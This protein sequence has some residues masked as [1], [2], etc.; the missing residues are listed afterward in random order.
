MTGEAVRNQ[1]HGVSN[2]F[3]QYNICVLIKLTDQSINTFLHGI[4]LIL[5]ILT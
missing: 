4:Q 2:S 1:A 5:R 3:R